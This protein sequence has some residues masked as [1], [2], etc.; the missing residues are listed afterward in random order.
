MTMIIT[1]SRRYVVSTTSRCFVDLLECKTLAPVGVH[2]QLG[3][4]RVELHVPVNA[5]LRILPVI[6]QCILASLGRRS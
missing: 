6:V 5:P 4:A 2:Q 1:I 3:L